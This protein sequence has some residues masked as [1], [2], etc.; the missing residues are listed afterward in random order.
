MNTPKLD[1]AIEIYM[2]PR[3]EGETLASQCVTAVNKLVY[4]W[5]NDG[6][7][8]DNVHSGLQGWANDISSY[9]NWLFEHKLGADI[10]YRIYRINT[11][12]EYEELLEDLCEAVLKE[13]DLKKLAEQPADGSIYNCAGPF[14]FTDEPEEDDWDND[15]DEGW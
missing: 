7:V 10:L 6:D 1:K 4:K 13:E 15:E 12:R 11:E 9:A 8:F 14:E 2:A 3:G 5:W